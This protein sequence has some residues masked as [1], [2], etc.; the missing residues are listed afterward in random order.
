MQA[1]FWFLIL[2]SC[3]KANPSY[4]PSDVRTP[5]WPNEFEITQNELPALS[6]IFPARSAIGDN[7]ISTQL[8]SPALSAR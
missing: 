3:Q 2:F 8:L 4:A 7:L 6:P 5:S 1:Q